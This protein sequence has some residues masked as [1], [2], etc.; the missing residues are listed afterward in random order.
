MI[1]RS[2]IGDRSCDLLVLGD[3]APLV[4]ASDDD[5]RRHGDRGEQRRGIGSGQERADLAGVLSRRGPLHHAPEQSHERVVGPAVRVHHRRQPRIGQRAHALRGPR[6]RAVTCRAL[7]FAGLHTVDA[8]VEQDERSHAFG[9]EPPDLE[10][11]PA[12]HRVAD[13]V[14]VPSTTSASD[15][16][17]MSVS[18]S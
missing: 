18:V 5:E 7:G 13:D 4:V 6:C 15:A 9:R 16:R 12:T 11:D 1:S 2:G 17:A 14:D 8:G 10:G 3:G